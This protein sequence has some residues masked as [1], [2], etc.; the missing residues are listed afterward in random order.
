[1]QPGLG[2]IRV[3]ELQNDN[4]LR[5]PIAFQGFARSAADDVFAAILLDRRTCRFL[6]FFVLDRFGYFELDDNVGR[7][8][9][10]S[11]RPLPSRNYDPGDDAGDGANNRAKSE[12]KRW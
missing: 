8:A 7:H 6:V 9:L 12:R 1:M 4:A 5:V 2:A 10:P 3:V 11:V